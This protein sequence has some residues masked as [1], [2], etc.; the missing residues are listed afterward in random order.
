MTNSR[1]PRW[2]PRLQ[3]EE[4]PSTGE[5]GTGERLQKILAQA[6]VASRRAAE[7]L[8]AAGRVS[9]NGK[10]VTEMGTRANSATDV[11]VVDGRPLKA[12]GDT[13]DVQ[14]LVY[15]ALH[16]PIGVV[17]TAKDPHGRPTVLSMIAGAKLVEQGLRVYPVGR[18]DADSTGLV[19]LTN[20]G[21][22]T[23]R[24]THPR[25]GVEK[26][27]R[28]LARGRIAEP[29]LQR[30]RDGVE[31]EGGLTAPAKVDVTSTREGNTWLRITIREGR[32]RQVRLMTAAVG[33]Q[34]IELQRVRFGP[35]D[36]GTL[37]PGKWRNLAIHEVHALRKAVKLKAE[38][39]ASI[40]KVAHTTPEPATRARAG[41]GARRPGNSGGTARPGHPASRRPG[42]G[43]QA[44]SQQTRPPG[45]RPPSSG[46]RPSPSAP[47]S[48]PGTFVRSGSPRSG[49]SGSRPGGAPVGRRPYSPRPGTPT[50]RPRN[51]EGL[52]GPARGGGGPAGRGPGPFPT[53]RP[54]PPPPRGPGFAPPFRTRPTG[55]T[56]GPSGF[57]SGP[58]RRPGRPTGGG[59]G[60]PPG[61]PP[62]QRGD[63]PTGPSEGFRGRPTGRGPVRRFPSNNPSNKRRDE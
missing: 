31:I 45:S 36:L 33:H 49:P 17:S 40:A 47:R 29:E 59:Q 44:P 20:D 1:P 42:Q 5:P 41:G 35:I 48:R 63:R 51:T 32:K 62:M 53:R 2:A 14:R 21:D 4:P 24:L 16:K 30:L 34:V 58:P 18:L 60:R 10:V 27:Y 8:I 39:G 11:I 54:G 25:F 13:G 37:E 43:T 9:V 19:L 52:S 3:P 7:E 6:G 22:L 26:E 56:R 61:R 23:F 57:S 38:E 46:P 50:D 55:G 28:V 12:K 15:I